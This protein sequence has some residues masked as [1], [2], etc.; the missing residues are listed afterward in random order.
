VLVR[1]ALLWIGLN[2]GIL[3]LLAVVDMALLMKRW[4]GRGTR[5]AVPVPAPAEEPEREVSIA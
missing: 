2:L 4:V 1:A 3:A 5:R